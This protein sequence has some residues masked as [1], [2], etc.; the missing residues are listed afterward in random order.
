MCG[1]KN[2]TFVHFW[3]Q[4][5]HHCVSLLFHPPQLPN[6][7]NAYNVDSLKA[8]VAKNT[9]MRQRENTRGRTIVEEEETETFVSWRES[10]SA[11]I[12]LLISCRNITNSSR[13]RARQVQSKAIECQSER[14]GLEAVGVSRGIVNKLLRD[15]CP[16]A[17]SG[18]CCRQAGYGRN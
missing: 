13:G 12:P 15:P 7:A 6:V 5:A 1:W 2:G 3:I 17:Q 16:I 9:A 11:I 10:L 14:E 18:E 4:G 8:V